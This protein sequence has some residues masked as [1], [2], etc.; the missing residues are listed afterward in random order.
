MSS[1]GLKVQK[2]KNKNLVIWVQDMTWCQQWASL[3][4]M[5]P[6]HR[7][8]QSKNDLRI[9]KLQKINFQVGEVNECLPSWMKQTYDKVQN[10]RIS[11][12]RDRTESFSGSRWG[13]GFISKTKCSDIQ[14]AKGYL[15]IT[16]D[17]QF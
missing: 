9:P 3:T 17:K 8:K 12:E 7:K 10:G 14:K 1:E 16:K 2:G 5:R 4:Y 11:K 15:E 13:N 6:Q